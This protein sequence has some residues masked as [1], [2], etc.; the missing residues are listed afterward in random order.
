MAGITQQVKDWNSSGRK[1]TQRRCKQRKGT[2]KTDTGKASGQKLQDKAPDKSSTQFCFQCQCHKIGLFS[3]S[4][5][6]S[7]RTK[8]NPNLPGRRISGQ[9]HHTGRH[10]R[11][12]EQRA[13]L[14][15]RERSQSQSG[16]LDVVDRWIALRRWPSGS[17]SGVQ[18]LKSM[19]VPPKLSRHGTHGGLQC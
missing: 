9:D 17:R 6:C 1:R 15:K 18:T 13:V 5:F 19:T 16:G 11:S 8:Q 14:G 10:H 7:C 3:S 4:A 12:Q 2:E